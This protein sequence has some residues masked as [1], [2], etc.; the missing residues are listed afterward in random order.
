M[1]LQADGTA[2]LKK[3]AQNTAIPNVSILNAILNNYLP[4]T[5]VAYAGLSRQSIR[6][7]YGDKKYSYCKILPNSVA[8][9][10]LLKYTLARI[11]QIVDQ[12]FKTIRLSSYSFY[13]EVNGLTSC[14]C[15][16]FK[17]QTILSSTCIMIDGPK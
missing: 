16:L 2:V 15:G 9:F 3:N 17:I 14:R 4:L 1:G 8:C 6:S 11:M 7:S 5:H 12:L 10:T 13:F